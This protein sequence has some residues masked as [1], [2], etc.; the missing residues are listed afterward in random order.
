MNHMLNKVRKIVDAYEKGLWG[1]NVM[2]EESNPHLPLNSEEN[3]LYFTLPMALNYQRNSYKL[4][5]AAL[6]TYNDVQTRDVFDVNVAA[7][8][9]DDILRSKLLKHKVALQPNNHIK[10][11]K[12]YAKSI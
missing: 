11:W 7:N 10:I 1:S 9:D 4:W 8:L 12:A 5:E 3:R 6:A 2:P